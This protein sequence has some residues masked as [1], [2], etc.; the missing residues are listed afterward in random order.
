VSAPRRTARRATA[1]IEPE[2]DTVGSRDR[3]L[4]A[5]ERL[6]GERGYTAASI[7]MISRASG[8]SAS[9]IYWF[10]GS[11]ED[12][13]AAVVERGVERWMRD[14]RTLN[15]GAGDLVELLEASARTV[16]GHP[17]FLRVLFMIILD[18]REGAPKARAALRAAW[19][20]VESRIE[21]VMVRHYGLDSAKEAAK[22]GRLARFTM[23]FFDGVFLDS[24]IDPEGTRI[25]DL[26]AD[27]KR[28]LDAI[29]GSTVR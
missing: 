22:A 16:A 20:G 6:V 29:A 9:S 19:R 27:L 26:L 13:L 23:A 14:Q 5:A 17:D 8:L 1:P 3:I 4:D 15:A 18:G 28:A 11:K 24:Q 25:P 12:L 2:A 21:R 7:S 10:F